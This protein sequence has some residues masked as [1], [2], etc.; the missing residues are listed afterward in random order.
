MALTYTASNRIMIPGKGDLR[1]T[2]A[3]EF[4]ALQAAVLD[5][6]IDGI[7]ELT[8][9]GSV[10]LTTANGT[11]TGDQA[12]NK[13]LVLAGTGG[14]LTVPEAEKIYIMVN[15]CTG[16]VTVTQGS[17]TT[18]T[19]PPGHTSIVRCYAP[20]GFNPASCAYSVL[21]KAEGVV[22]QTTTMTAVN[23]VSFTIPAGIKRV[24]AYLSGVRQTTGSDKTVAMALTGIGTVASPTMVSGVTYSGVFDATW[25][26]TSLKAE[27]GL[28]DGTRT[29]TPTW[30]N[31]PDT[32]TA[33]TFTLSAA[34]NFDAAGTIT[35]R[36]YV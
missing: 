2:Y 13:M 25:D 23:A 26:G 1:G 32:P 5:Q 17:G 16:A 4:W 30:V 27:T 3:T 34:A 21:P 29:I 14:T 19:I 28:S 33:M 36:G 35:F 7:L 10:T 9:S 6:A 31:D 22:L 8:V 20:G 24:R 11:V 18:C 12:R 15:N